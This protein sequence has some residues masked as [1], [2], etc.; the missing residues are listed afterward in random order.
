MLLFR[1]FQVLLEPLQGQLLTATQLHA[2]MLQPCH[3]A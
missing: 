2:V 3:F 1:P